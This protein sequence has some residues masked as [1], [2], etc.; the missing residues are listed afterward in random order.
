ML[1]YFTGLRFGDCCQFELEFIE[2]DN[3]IIRITPEKTERDNK[4]LIIPLHPT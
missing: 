1:S 4:E 2:W 3:D